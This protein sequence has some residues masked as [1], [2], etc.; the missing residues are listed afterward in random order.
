MKKKWFGLFAKVLLPSVLVLPA[1]CKKQVQKPNIIFVMMDDLGYGQLGLYN[2]TINTSDF[3]PFF[4]QLVNRYQGYSLDTALAFSKKASPTLSSLAKDGVIFTNAYTSSSLCAPS[5]LGIATGTLQNRLGIYTNEDCENHGI[6]PGTHLAEILKKEGY[7]TAHIG[8]W[9]IGVRNIQI[10]NE[11]LKRHGIEDELSYSQIGRS[12]P[13]IFKEVEAE[14]YFGSVTEEQNPLNNGFDYYFGY[15]NWASQYYNSTYIWENF[16]HAGKQ[17]G[18]NTDVFTDK[19]LNFMAQQID[20][21]SPF[22]VQL[23]YHAVH[24]SIEPKAPAIYFD[25]FKSDSYDLNNFF[26]HVNG[27]DTNLKRIVE[28]L[29]SKGQFENTIIVFTSDNGAM[30]GGSYDGNKTGSPLP[31]NTPFSG[32]KGNFHQGGIRVPLFFYWPAG[33]KKSNISSQLVSTMDILPTVISAAGGKLP[34]GIDGKSL[35]PLF[36]N[37]DQPAHD[38]LLW[39]GMHSYAWGYL[40]EK[41]TKTHNTERKFAPPAWALV[42]G[43]YLL[44]FTGTLD[45]GI[46]Y[47]FIDGRG[48]I[49]ELFNIN[50]DPTEKINL[51]GKMPDMVKTMSE[52]YFKEFDKFPPPVS[53]EREKWEELVNSRNLIMEGKVK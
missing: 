42:K 21:E 40:I 27:V 22:Y 14:G 52:I 10:I 34:E 17:T 12:H 33:I 41:S 2:D 4:V 50:N 46:Y 38:H 8:K 29:K 53:W 1:G 7:K 11:A 6:V 18:Y 9:H 45:P 24:D 25:Q 32:T 31:G 35:L 19:A 5:R 51:A 23:H 36:R 49:I 30:C 39:A 15:N 20:D 44:R 26:A 3:D 13:E 37:P 48:P 28:F 16:K 43:D 47:D